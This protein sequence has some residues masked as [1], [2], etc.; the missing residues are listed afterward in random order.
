MVANTIASILM[1]D[2]RVWDRVLAYTAYRSLASFNFLDREELSHPRVWGIVSISIWLAYIALRGWNKLS[3]FDRQQ[4]LW[5][6]C[7]TISFFYYLQ[8]DL[9]FR[10]WGDGET[11]AEAVC[12]E[13]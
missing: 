9:E 1:P 13:L 6:T 2:M 4:L 10:G 3:L 5:A 12:M 8:H 11:S 7:S